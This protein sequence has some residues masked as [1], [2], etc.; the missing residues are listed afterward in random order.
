MGDWRAGLE[1]H[2][3]EEESH[4]LSSPYGESRAAT[5]WVR[6][7]I[8][9]APLMRNP[10]YNKGLAFSEVERDRLYLRGLMPPAVMT[11][12]VQKERVLANLNVMETD[13]EKYLYLSS[14]QDRNERLFYR[15]LTDH[16]EELLPIVHEP[17]MGRACLKYGLMFKNMPRGLFISLKDRGYVRGIFKNWPE[18][19]VR[20]IAITDGEN[21]LGLGDLGIQ[22]MGSSVAT[23][24]CYTACAGV[25][26]HFTLP[27][28]LDVGCN[29]DG[30]L[31]SPFY[32]GLKRRRAVG[33]SVTLLW[34]EVIGA[35]QVKGRPAVGEQL[36]DCGGGCSIG[37]HQR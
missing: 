14:L 34:D 19:R 7:V 12:E 26:P 16:I 28:T 31:K 3:T 25:V 18:R 27:V 13:F 37:G 5:P 6:S 4:Q 15:V 30:L 35:A 24:A 17:T 33:E 32:V 10:K 1:S 36:G 29:N 2:E 8:V 20:A 11:Q 23:L 22:G 21:I 9:G